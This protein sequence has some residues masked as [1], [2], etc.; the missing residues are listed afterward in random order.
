MKP[1]STNTA[2]SLLFNARAAMAVATLES[3]P[4]L[5]PMMAFPSPTS[6]FYFLDHLADE[7][8]HLPIRRGLADFENEVVEHLHAVFCM[9]DFGV[10]LKTVDGFFL[11]V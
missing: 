1:W 2:V 7:V 10:P 3:M 4:P 9:N 8:F 6:F 11:C 5:K